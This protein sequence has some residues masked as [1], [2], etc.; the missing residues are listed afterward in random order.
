[1]SVSRIEPSEDQITC[2]ASGPDEGPIVML[3]L[4]RFKDRADGV[5]E[6]DGI[7]G[8]EAYGRYGEAIASNLE[9]VGASLL[10]TLRCTDTVI[11]PLEERWDLAVLVRYPSRAAFLQMAGDPD[12]T[13]KHELRIAALEDSRLICC[14]QL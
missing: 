12:F 7:S 10:A 9:H 3:N 1:M 2:F 5:Q 8:A 14:Q 13:A 11:G 4:L 6:A